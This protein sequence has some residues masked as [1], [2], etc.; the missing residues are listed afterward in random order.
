MPG[1]EQNWRGLQGGVSGS[2]THREPGLRKAL[3]GFRYRSTRWGF[4]AYVERTVSGLLARI[5]SPAASD[6]IAPAEIVLL[7]PIVALLLPPT[8]T[9]WEPYWNAAL[10]TA[11]KLRL[12]LAE[13][14]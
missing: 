2:E 3:N 11:V 5:M 7:P 1:N 8:S 6:W 4:P 9:S 13:T 10:P 14:V 12:F